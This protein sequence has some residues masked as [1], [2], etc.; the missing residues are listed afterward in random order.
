LGRETDARLKFDRDVLAVIPTT[1]SRVL[2]AAGVIRK[3][4]G[5][6]SKKGTG[7]GRGFAPKVPPSN[8]GWKR[9]ER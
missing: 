4:T 6:H 2:N 5:K 8:P 7:F 3:F 1:S 9:P